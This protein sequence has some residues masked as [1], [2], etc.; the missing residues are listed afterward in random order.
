[1]DGNIAHFGYCHANVLS[2]VETVYTLEKLGYIGEF[3]FF[4]CTKGS[5]FDNGVHQLINDSDVLEMVA[6]ASEQASLGIY[7]EH[8]KSVDAM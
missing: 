5:D 7:V 8:M 6:I 2:L 1:M 4:R 3:K